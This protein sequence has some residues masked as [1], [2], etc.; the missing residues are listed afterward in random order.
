MDFTLKDCLILQ[1]LVQNGDYGDI[2]K[3]ALW[4]SRKTWKEIYFWLS[5]GTSSLSFFFNA[6]LK[7]K[8]QV[9]IICIHNKKDR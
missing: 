2:Q 3:I 9:Y 4:K 6:I 7:L 8:R 5:F 1:C